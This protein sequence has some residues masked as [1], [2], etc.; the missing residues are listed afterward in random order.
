M[1]LGKYEIHRPAALSLRAQATFARRLLRF[2]MFSMISLFVLMFVAGVGGYFLTQTDWFHRWSAEQLEKVLANELEAK[3]E[4]SSLR[5]NIFKGVE[6]DSVR[7]ITRG[8]TLLSASSLTMSY[9]LEPLLIRQI[10]ISSVQL[11]NP[12]IRILRSKTDSSWNV[13]HI[14]KPNPDTTAP[15]PFDWGIYVR[16]VEI[17]NGCISV[18]DSLS[19]QPLAERIHYTRTTLDGVNLSL[20]AMLNLAAQQFS[21]SINHMQF[22]ER[23]TG[24]QAR[25]LRLSA[26]VDTTHAELMTLRLV[27]PTT[28]LHVRASLDSVNVFGSDFDINKKE[29]LVFLDADSLDARDVNLFLPPTFSLNGDFAL[30]ATVRG[31]LNNLAINAE[32]IRTRSTD[33]QGKV[34]LEHLSDGKEFI[35]IAELTPSHASY[36][37]VRAALP[38][39]QLPPLNFLN[40]LSIRPSR[41]YGKG[42]SLRCDIDATGAFGTVKGWADIRP[43]AL[44]GYN[45]DVQCSDFDLSRIT[46]SSSTQSSLTGRVTMQGNG[47]T[48][49]DMIANVSVNMASSSFAGRAFESLAFYAQANMG[50]FRVDSLRAQFPTTSEDSSDAY[51]DGGKRTLSAAG[52]IDMHNPRQPSYNLAT[53]FNHFPLARLVQLPTL[54]K[55]LSGSFVVAGSGFHPDSLDGNMQAKFEE[56]LLADRALFPFKLD[57]TLARRDAQHRRLTINSDL[58]DAALEGRFRLE[59]F[60]QVF[61]AQLDLIDKYI[62]QRTAVM[63]SD[64]AETPFLRPYNLPSDTLDMRYIVQIRNLSPISPFLQGVKLSAQGSANGVL[65][66]TPDC[67]EFSVDT[68]SIRRF[69]MQIGNTFMISQ[70]L[71]LSTTIRSENMNSAPTMMQ[72]DVIASCDSIF[73]VDN[74]RFYV[75][76]VWLRFLDGRGQFAVGTRINKQIPLRARGEIS[77]EENEY[78]LTLD[79][80]HVGLNR[81]FSFSSLYKVRATIA[82]RG[83][84]VTSLVLKHDSSRATIGFNGVVNT[85]RFDAMNILI[86]NL[87]V[88]VL[89]QIPQIAAFQPLDF[90]S[91]VVDSLSITL[92]DKFAQPRFSLAGMNSNLRYNEVEIGTQHVA[93]MYDGSNLQASS[94]I[95]NPR[96]SSERRTLEMAIHQL[97]LQ[98][99]L[100]PFSMG[101]RNNEPVNITLAA[102][103]L[104][105]AA[106]APFIPGVTQLS[107]KADAAMTIKGTTPSDVNYGGEVSFKGASFLV[108]A[109]NILYT[110]NG[111]LSLKNNIVTVDSVNVYNIPTDNPGGKAMA[112]GKI[113]IDGFTIDSLDIHARIPN[114]LLVMSNATKASNPTL[115]GRTLISTPTSPDTSL[116]FFG[117]LQEPKLRGL[118]TINEA[119]LFFP[120][121]AGSV[122]TSSTFRYQ[123]VGKGFVMSEEY[124][125]TTVS[126]TTFEA[127]DEQPVEQ[128]P[129]IVLL[130]SL[131]DLLDADVGVRFKKAIGIRMDFSTLEQLNADNVSL[132]S[133]SST[134]RFARR[135]GQNQLYGDVS[136]TKAKYKFYKNFEAD[137]K[138]SFPN[139][140][141]DNPTM[142]LKAEYKGTRRINDRNQEYKVNIKIDST[143]KNPRIRL[144]YSIDGIENPGV[145]NKEEKITANALMLILFD[146]TADE[147]L[148]GVSIGSSNSLGDAV[149]SGVSSTASSV[150]SAAL[151]NTFQGSAIKDVKIDFSGG[152]LDLN[153]ARIQITGAL[154]GDVNWSLGGSLADL[155]SGSTLTIDASLGALISN[156]ALR[157]VVLQFIRSTN[158]GQAA[159]RNDKE[160]EAKIG[161]RFP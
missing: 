76:D 124:V 55:M 98:I 114:S 17:V 155:S 61:L 138:M 89:R 78:Q 8:D 107:G 140:E 129:R 72:A 90:L 13:A 141:I 22:T 142:S 49:E 110:G 33:V 134:L 10:V 136:V 74:T 66:G 44:L 35:Y 91:G 139:G 12:D 112:Y 144:S 38:T 77:L 50:L 159:T 131:A 161:V 57:A 132:P 71:Q 83:M 37:D 125:R 126:D 93:A 67:Y 117:R 127:Q 75:P 18:N 53:E 48:L 106:V 31:N 135:K 121:S 133:A 120:P 45:A 19:Y 11:N 109:T 128:I 151:T 54:P 60:G 137:G 123:R 94:Y 47:T 154:I 52:T 42:D 113:F 34:F 96:I 122:V 79:S 6:F 108:S 20:S 40:N 64:T 21:V 95:V 101:T 36:D 115:Y 3:V 87:D 46:G 130:P 150:V 160:W 25:S 65:R 97:P 104:S 145:E 152:S 99:S 41:V 27:S 70:P 69:S 32:R 86:K 81:A 26:S 15:K 156:D 30:E 157:N 82:P 62:R 100:M 118:V 85:T 146:K 14:V 148:G 68:A 84:M 158:S 29:A 16:N 2:A 102:N 43:R 149:S 147:L 4:F 23:R 28:N 153:T 103:G 39:V 58:V 56:F 88:S 59:S 51:F 5:V 73:R 105:M 63:Q 9:E 7:L 143:K 119:S 24:F 1:K 80:L 92:N 111:H 116:Y